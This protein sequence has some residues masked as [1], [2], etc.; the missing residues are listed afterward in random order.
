MF[1]VL[2]IPAISFTPKVSNGIRR[3]E[4]ERAYMRRKYMNFL[5]L[6]FLRKKRNRDTEKLEHRVVLNFVN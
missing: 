1:Y 5:F 2:K 4:N 6:E 3:R